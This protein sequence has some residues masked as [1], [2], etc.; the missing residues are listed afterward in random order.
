MT[1]DFL[2]SMDQEAENMVRSSRTA[3]HKEA[4]GAFIGKRKPAFAGR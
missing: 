2:D 3:D 4:V 1:S